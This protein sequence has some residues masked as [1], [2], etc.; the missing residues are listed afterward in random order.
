MK[1]M[2]TS[3]GKPAPA[4]AD[5]FNGPWNEF[6]QA[7]FPSLFP[8]P[9]AFGAR[10]PELFRA[11]TPVVDVSEDDKELVVKAEV[12][13]MSEKDLELSWL[14]G[15]L[16]MKG[17]KKGEKEEKEDK[18]KKNTWHR[19]SWY[20]SFTRGIPLG[21][22]ADFAKAQARYKDGVVTVHI[23]KVRPAGA[24]ANTITIE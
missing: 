18:S 1:L 6:F 22:N 21:D 8:A 2:R 19:E 4:A 3:N 5:P 16:Y 14:D 20:G 7:P 11:K 10:W 15:V 24:K 23:P 13:G 12:P 17:E 9:A